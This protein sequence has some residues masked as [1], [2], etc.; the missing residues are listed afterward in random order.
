L[1]VDSRAVSTQAAERGLSGPAI[2]Q[3]I[4][5][6]RVRAIADGLS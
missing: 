5:Q 2:G 1:S 3:E 6:A 4:Y